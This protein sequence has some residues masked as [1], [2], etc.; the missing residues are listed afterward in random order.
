MGCGS[1]SACGGRPTVCT[2]NLRATAISPG[3]YFLPA[4]Q[5][6]AAVRT[7][8]PPENIRFLTDDPRQRHLRDD[9]GWQRDILPRGKAFPR[10]PLMS[11]ARRRLLLA[12]PAALQ[13]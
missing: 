9:P 1:S 2:I 10:A 4:W 7:R 13:A 11:S 8:I 5:D 3:A 6:C 12:A